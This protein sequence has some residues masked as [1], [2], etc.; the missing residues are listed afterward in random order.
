MASQAVRV[1]PLVSITKD[2]VVLEGHEVEFGIH[3]NGTSPVYPLEIP[4]TVSGTAD[5]GDHG[6]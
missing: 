3:L 6:V 5:S 1:R 4:F 2:Q